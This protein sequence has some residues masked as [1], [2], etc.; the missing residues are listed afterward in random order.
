MQREPEESMAVEGERDRTCPVC[1]LPFQFPL[2]L[3]CGHEFCY[4]CLKGTAELNRLCPL[5]RTVIPA[6]F[7]RKAPAADLSDVGA[8]ATTA[9]W[10]YEG[11]EGYWVYDPR[12]RDELEA[13]YQREPTGTAKILVAGHIYAV[14]FET[15]QQRRTDWQ[16][17]IRSVLRYESEACVP[18]AVRVKGV[19]GVVDIASSLD[20]L[21]L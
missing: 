20:A 11:Q 9:V 15:M 13:A 21:S 12:T 5:C 17:R 2:S 16:G 3:P 10:L 8:P 6:G 4:L 7:F 18:P 14:D 19:C 1:L